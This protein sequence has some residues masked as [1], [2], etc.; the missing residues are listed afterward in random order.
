VI[1]SFFHSFFNRDTHHSVSTRLPFHISILVCV[2]AVIVLVGGISALSQI[3]FPLIQFIR[4]THVQALE[5]LGRIGN[6]LGHGSTLVFISLLLFLAGYLWKQ[7]RLKQIGVQTLVAHGLSGLITQIIK[8]SIGRPRPRLAHQ[9]HWQI[10]P[11]FQSGLD[12]F[13]SGHS[14]A[15]FAV[16]AILARH[17]P[18]Y[19]WMLYGSA[20]FVA[21][22]RII[23]GSHF[24]SD[25]C[26]GAFLGYVI[27]YILAQPIQH[28]R[29]S[30]IESLATGLPFFVTGLGLFW[31]T[32]HKPDLDI[33]Y[34]IILGTGILVTTV[35]YGIRLRTRLSTQPPLML[36]QTK[37]TTSSL[38][39]ALGVALCSGSFLITTLAALSGVAWWVVRDHQIHTT[40]ESLHDE[41]SRR[42]AVLLGTEVLLGLGI[43]SFVSLIYQLRGI[44]PLV[45]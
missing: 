13:P 10:G 40:S 43:L 44:L 3:D 24:P 19:A 1:T 41:D 26:V 14:S 33:L 7:H 27:G 20:A 17:F 22:S 2:I 5:H 6:Q 21:F 16:A 42:P 4:A 31:I 28:W 45:S 18:R 29:T 11:S 37:L 39:V 15:S 30:F 25:A 9:D 38:L 35:G 36:R 8:H 34:D 23:K 32:V 12:A